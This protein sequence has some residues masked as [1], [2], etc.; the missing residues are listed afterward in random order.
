LL[1]TYSPAP[2]EWGD[3][4][5][6]GRLSLRGQTLELCIV[7]TAQLFF[8]VRNSNKDEE[9]LDRVLWYLAALRHNGQIVGDDT[10][11]AKVKGGYLVTTSVPDTTALADRFD[12]KWVRKHLR[13]LAAVGVGRPKVTYL[14][15][16]PESRLPCKC[17]RRPFLILFTTSL[18]AEPPVRCGACFGPIGVYKLPDTNETDGRRGLL[19]WQDTY[20]AVDWLFIATGPGERFAHDQ[21][22]RYDSQLS[23]EGRDLARSLEKNVRLPVYYYLSKYFG[24]SDEMERKRKCPSCDRA[25]L[26]KEPLHR[27]FDFQCRRCRLLS[28]VA[29]EVRLEGVRG[30]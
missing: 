11:V 25:W 7:I 18:H 1:R 20:Q 19:W 12:N 9:T 4:G 17:R 5:A 21:L 15:T 8:R 14:G 3:L 22:S 10:P 23:A 16:D 6:E 24:R 30:G 13:E 26:L 2:L 28:N 27:I 29:F